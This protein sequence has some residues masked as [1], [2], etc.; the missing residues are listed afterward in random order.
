M[1]AAARSRPELR[2]TFVEMLFA[3]TVAEIA[4]QGA[5]VAKLDLQS[6]LLPVVSHLLLALIVVATSWIGWARSPSAANKVDLEPVFSWSFM[7]LLLDVLLVVFYFILVRG[8]E[9]VRDSSG[10]VILPSAYHES[11]WILLIFVGYCVWDV[12]TKAIMKAPPGDTVPGYWSR[13]W[14]TLAC[15]VVSGLI[16]CT[17][18]RTSGTF[19]VVAVDVG[20]ILLVLGFRAFKE[21]RM[22]LGGFFLLGTFT[23]VLGALVLP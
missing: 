11:L 2:I 18:G 12:I 23:C 17:A 7:V 3:L 9:I 19:R 4:V 20:L 6:K 21:T 8:V 1:A 14:S 13:G 5:E 16:L 10:V 22:A 15:L